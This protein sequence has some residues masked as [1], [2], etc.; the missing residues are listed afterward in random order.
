MWQMEH[1]GSYNNCFFWYE[2]WERAV[3]GHGKEQMEASG[4]QKTE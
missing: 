1:F 2:Q 4:Q 3:H